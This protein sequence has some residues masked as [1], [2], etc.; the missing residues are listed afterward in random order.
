M[1]LFSIDASTATTACLFIIA[2]SISLLNAISCSF[3]Y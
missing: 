3:S 2:Y 1:Y